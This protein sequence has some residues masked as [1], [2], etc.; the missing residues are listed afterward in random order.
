MCVKSLEIIMKITIIFLSL[1]QRHHG[2]A[3]RKDSG[4][5]PERGRLLHALL[6]LQHQGVDR[7]GQDDDAD[8]NPD[9][10]LIQHV[11]AVVRIRILHHSRGGILLQDPGYPDEGKR[12]GAGQE[13][14]RGVGNEKTSAHR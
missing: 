5:Q 3:Q 6:P 7:Q 2:T 10:H 8:G 12:Q 4:G 11:L 9:D 1:S 13:D 14:G